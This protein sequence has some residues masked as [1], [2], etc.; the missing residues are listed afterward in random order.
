[1]S[2]T[3]PTFTGT[4]AEFHRFIGP[5]LR[6][7]VQNLTRSAKLNA[8]TCQHCENDGQLD[9]AHVQGRDRPALARMIVG[10]AGDDEIVTV[11]L[12]E[13]D[14]QFKEAHVPLEKSILFL[15]KPCHAKYDRVIGTGAGRGRPANATAGVL[16]ITLHPANS[17]AFK[18]ALFEQKVA[19]IEITYEDGRLETKPWYANRFSMSS[20]VYGNLRSRP[21]F[22]AGE[23]QTRGIASLHVRVGGDI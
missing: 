20:N 7:V 17:E 15:C 11:D 10:P 5:Y 22:R 3:P 13:F 8:G 12:A 6:N 19:T 9:A 16:P 1:M 2:T 23:W 14:R 18:R 4:Y 21:E